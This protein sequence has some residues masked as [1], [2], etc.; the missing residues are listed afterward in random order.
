MKRDKQAEEKAPKVLQ[1]QIAPKG[2]RAFSTAAR[3]NQAALSVPESSEAET[4]GHIFD[5]PDLPLPKDSHLKYRYDPIIKQVTGLLMQDGKLGVAQRV[6]PLVFLSI[7][8]DQLIRMRNWTL[9]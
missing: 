9:C 2:S 3:R 1:E 7:Y 5:L 4:L 6:R 8:Y